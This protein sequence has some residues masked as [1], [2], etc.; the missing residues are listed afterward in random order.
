M[1]EFFKDPSHDRTRFGIGLAIGAV[2]YCVEC[3]FDSCSG[4]GLDVAVAHS[5]GPS[6]ACMRFEPGY[7]DLASRLV[8]SGDGFTGLFHD[9][10]HAWAWG[11]ACV[12]EQ[13]RFGA[14]GKEWATSAWW[15]M[16]VA[17]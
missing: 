12:L 5:S 11:G 6:G 14:C 16:V 3:H 8:F 13:T 17:M 15:F 10:G 4:S 9:R 2:R 7:S 1:D